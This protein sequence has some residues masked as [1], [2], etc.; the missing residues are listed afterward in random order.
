MEKFL[1]S[2]YI[3]LSS[4]QVILIVLHNVLENL[5]FISVSTN[6]SPSSLNRQG[7]R[8]LYDDVA[9]DLGGGGDA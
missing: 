7:R 1:C 2:S 8:Y 4:M 6:T 9:A 3:Q 5:A